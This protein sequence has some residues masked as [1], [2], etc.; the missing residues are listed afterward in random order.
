MITVFFHCVVR[1]DACGNATE[2][3]TNDIEHWLGSRVGEHRF[4][5]KLLPY[6]PIAARKI[7]V[8][9]DIICTRSANMT[10]RP[11]EKYPI[12]G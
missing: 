12:F 7:E 1:A 8:T 6:G 5:E 11:N 4:H 10:C 3:K 9:V 2:N